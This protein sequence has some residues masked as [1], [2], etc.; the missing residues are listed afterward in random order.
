MVLLRLHK[1]IRKASKFKP[2]TLVI[3]FALLPAPYFLLPPLTNLPAFGA[4]RIAFSYPPFG[5]FYLSTNSLEVFAKQGKINNE[6]AFYARRATPQQLVQLREF[7]QRRFQVSPTMVSQFTYSPLGEKVIYG[8]GELLQ[9]DTRKNGFYALRSAMIISAA[10]PEGMTV[11]NI[12]RRFPAYSIRL[13]LDQGFEI[14]SEFSKFL[15]QRDTLVAAIQ[16]KA[17]AEATAIAM[18]DFLPKPDLRLPGPFSWQKATSI[19]SFI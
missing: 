1:A 18:V 8:L 16:R 17:E 14:V 3:R 7:L 6:L 13:N 11:L 19:C 4:E 5:E 2:L 15:K 9:T 10:D 12:V